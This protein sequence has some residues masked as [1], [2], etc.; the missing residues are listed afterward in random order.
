[1]KNKLLTHIINLVFAVLFV[2]VVIAGV[3]LTAV[4]ESSAKYRDF[5][6]EARQDRID[7]LFL[8]S[9][10]MIDGVNPV[11]LYEEY[12]I[13]SYNMGGHGSVMAAT[14]WELVN[15]LDYCRP[16]LVVIDTYMLEKDYRLLDVMSGQEP[17]EEISTSID[18]LHLNM[19]CFPLSRN[20]ILALNDL[21][22]SSDIRWQFIVPFIKYHSRWSSLKAD[23]FTGVLGKN[24][25]NL[26]MGAELQFRTDPNVDSYPLIRPDEY[27][28][29]ETLSME[30]L[31]KAVDYCQRNNINVIL[32][33]I[34][35]GAN[36]ERQQ[37]GNS[38]QLIAD[39]MNVPYLN[40]LYMPELVDTKTDFNDSGHLNNR[41]SFKVTSYL[42]EVISGL[43][44]AEDHRKDPSYSLWNER[45]AQYHDTLKSAACEA[46]DLYS[47]LALLEYDDISSIVFINH[48]SN[49]FY[50]QVLIHQ[51]EKLAGTRGIETVAGY[52]R[53]YCLIHDSKKNR[54]AETVGDVPIENFEASFGL[55]NYVSPEENYCLLSVGEDLTDNLLRYTDNANID[56]Q[57]FIYDNA[58]G[59][60]LGRLYFDDLGIG[61]R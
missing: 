54:H 50:D 24:A 34:P 53:S 52:H 29:K 23:D 42:G 40:L 3:R 12:G 48:N 27:L 55:V 1:M 11:Q 45:V 57:V 51:I 30:Y 37:A 58:D 38:A 32:V 46:D 28:E 18:Q 2:L 20:K 21:F 13:T 7:V 19:D 16:K 36:E 17:E 25:P 60:F 47:E 61:V 15:A 43:G 59:E 5:F 31:R 35:F 41:G 44:I 33:H 22:S 8:G 39:E 4:K 26:L 56:V 49:A 14:Y 6:K 10:H 9:S